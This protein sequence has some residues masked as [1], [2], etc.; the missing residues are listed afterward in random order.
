MS[1]DQK[2]NTLQYLS[3]N[4]LLVINKQGKIRELSTP[5]LVTAIHSARKLL[6]LKK[7]LVQGTEL[8]SML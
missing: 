4:C 1:K 2:G 7:Y 8:S 6:L 5:F 3:N